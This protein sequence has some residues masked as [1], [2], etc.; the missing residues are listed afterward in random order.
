MGKAAEADGDVGA[1]P[2]VLVMTGIG[3]LTGTDGIGKTTPL[4]QHAAHALAA[5]AS[6]KD[7]YPSPWISTTAA[8]TEPR[9]RAT[10]PD[11]LLLG[12]RVDPKWW[13]RGFAGRI[14]QYW[15]R[16]SP[17]ELRPGDGRGRTRTTARLRQ[18]AVQ[19]AAE[20]DEEPAPFVL[21]R[22]VVALAHHSPPRHEP[23]PI[24]PG[25]ADRTSQ[26]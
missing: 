14:Q 21:Q 17:R 22:P 12:L 15:D 23:R 2:P 10:P 19:P 7:S 1:G 20:P 13:V 6:P 11:Q 24:G 25:T 18:V 5:R 9:T 4:A 8:G 3:G 26:L 16:R